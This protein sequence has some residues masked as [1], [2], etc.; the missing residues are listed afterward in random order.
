MTTCSI[1]KDLILE[2][3]YT[4]FSLRFITLHYRLMLLPGRVE[5]N[6][7]NWCVITRFNLRFALILPKGHQLAFILV[8][9]ER[10]KIWCGRGVSAVLLCDGFSYR[11]K[12]YLLGRAGNLREEGSCIF[13]KFVQTVQA[14]SRRDKF[15]DLIL[16]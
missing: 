7:E 1:L 12:T 15:T 8:T 14:Y 16:W 10:A 2:L 5:F 13:L 4:C 11:N 6:L 3:F 9:R